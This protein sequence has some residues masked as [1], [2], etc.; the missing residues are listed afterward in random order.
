MKVINSNVTVGGTM[1]LGNNMAS[2][3]GEIKRFRTRTGCT[4]PFD[5]RLERR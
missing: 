3:G 4:K 5:V 1:E 2:R